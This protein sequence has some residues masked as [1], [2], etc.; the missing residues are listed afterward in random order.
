MARLED[1]STGTRL[2]GLAASGRASFAWVRHSRTSSRR[3]ESPR[4]SGAWWR[5]KRILSS[6]T[7][8]EVSCLLSCVKGV[9]PKVLANF[10]ILRVDS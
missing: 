4:P 3:A 1:L 5:S 2:T 7:R 9:G 8:D 6:G 10:F